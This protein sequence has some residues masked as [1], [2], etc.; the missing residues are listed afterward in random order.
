MRAGCRHLQR[1]LC[2]LLALDVA[3]IGIGRRHSLC[4]ALEGY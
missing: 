4:I 1:T 2:L 3:E